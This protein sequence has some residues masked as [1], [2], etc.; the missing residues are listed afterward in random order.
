MMHWH[1]ISTWNLFAKPL[2]QDI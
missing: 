2:V 1:R